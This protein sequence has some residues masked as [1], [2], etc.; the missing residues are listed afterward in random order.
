MS[1]RPDAARLRR[2]LLQRP[3]F[4][5]SPRCPLCG[6]ECKPALYPDHTKQCEKDCASEVIQACDKRLAEIW[7]T[8]PRGPEHQACLETEGQANG[9][10]LG[11]SQHHIRLRQPG[12]WHHENRRA[13]LA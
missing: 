3:G 4:Y 7:A 2:Q 10:T 8:E 11:R 13:R 9:R 5:P 6:S 12:P 1:F